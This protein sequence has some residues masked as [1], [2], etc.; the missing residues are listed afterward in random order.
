MT[1]DEI[2]LAIGQNDTE[3]VER[4]ANTTIDIAAP[5]NATVTLV[6]VYTDE[7]YD[8]IIEQL[9]VDDESNL[10]VDEIAAHYQPIQTVIKKLDE[11]D[12]SHEIRGG[13][14]DDLAERVISI[15]SSIEAD[16]L[17]IG[18]RR[19]S[20]TGKALFGSRAQDILMG[21]HC[22]VTLVHT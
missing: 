18:G 5:S 10:S 1:L 2:V 20:P 8:D 4:L 16:Y 11:N 14:S 15:T 12:I 13:I 7:E 3:M 19:H 22:P 6:H 9:H 17:L 21:A